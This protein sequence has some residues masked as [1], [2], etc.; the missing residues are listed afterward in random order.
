MPIS[1]NSLSEEDLHA[2]EEGGR[3]PI[4]Y[5]GS[6]L[7]FIYNKLSLGKGKLYIMEKRVIWVVN[8]KER[9]K[10][11]VTNFNQLVTNS[12]YLNHYEK[13][14]NFYLHL[15]NEVDN[16]CVD[17][18]NIALHAIT[19]DKKICS[20]SCV[21]I[22]LNGD[23]SHSYESD[24][25]GVTDLGSIGGEI[26]QKGDNTKGR[27]KDADSVK[28]AS[29][30][31]NGDGDVDG[32]GDG[33]GDGNGED[34]DS[35]DETITPEILIVSR[36]HSVDD[37]IFRQLSNMDN[38]VNGQEDEEDDDE[39]GEYNDGEEYTDGED[40]EETKA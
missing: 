12:A 6:E 36:N 8:K 18:S 20:D 15:L 7:E 30:N 33:D 31:E 11:K 14:R 35:Y 26:L 39:G 2:L 28:L 40:A 9:K 22:Q 3:E 27:S 17:S 23:M 38:S 4:L 19:S 34:E 21:Y 16:I 24:K 25:Y 10:E 37:I 5:K 1:L 29:Y 32:D 13:N